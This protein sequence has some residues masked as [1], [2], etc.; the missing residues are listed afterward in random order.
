VVAWW[1]KG[2]SDPIF[3]ATNFFLRPEGL[4]PLPDAF[5]DCNF[6]DLLPVRDFEIAIGVD[7]C[8]FQSQ[9]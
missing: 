2:Q 3:L 9:W 4:R 8:H 1:A 5:Y 6:G 7:C